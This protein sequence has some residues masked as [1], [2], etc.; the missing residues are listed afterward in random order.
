[1]SKRFKE[2]DDARERAQVAFNAIKSNLDL[3]VD[4]HIV[5]SLNEMRDAYERVI[6]FLE[7]RIK[8]Y[9]E[10]RWP[11]VVKM[12]EDKVKAQGRWWRLWK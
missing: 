2:I 11:K 7:L 1:M 5:A 6:G 8:C 4:G 10:E 12:A 3:R 9:Q